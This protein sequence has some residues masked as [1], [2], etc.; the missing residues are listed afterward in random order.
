MTELLKLFMHFYVGSIEESKLGQLSGEIRKMNNN[1]VLSQDPTNACPNCDKE[2]RKEYLKGWQCCIQGHFQ[3]TSGPQ[4]LNK[5]ITFSLDI[6][7]EGIAVLVTSLSL[8]ENAKLSAKEKYLVYQQIID[9]IYDN[10]AIF[11]PTL[12]TL[13]GCVERFASKDPE[14][15]TIDLSVGGVI[16]LG[17][18]YSIVIVEGYDL[19]SKNPNVLLLLLSPDYKG[20]SRVPTHIRLSEYLIEIFG[21]M[22]VYASWET[23]VIQGHV[24]I[25]QIPNY[26]VLNRL[27]LRVWYNCYLIDQL[28]TMYLEAIRKIE[29]TKATLEEQAKY[30][31]D[32]LNKLR[33]LRRKYT[34]IKNSLLEFNPNMSMRFVNLLKCSMLYSN[35]T[36]ILTS[37]QEKLTVLHEDYSHEYQSLEQKRSE[38]I[39]TS[40]Q[41]LAIV[42]ATFGIVQAVDIIINTVALSNMILIGWE[43][44]FGLEIIPLIITLLWFVWFRFK[45]SKS[46]RSE[47]PQKQEAGK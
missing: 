39:N 14:L 7:E 17:I 26:D 37:T 30:V 33:N 15:E 42:V 23:F 32:F 44:R 20:A 19:S 28:A 2:L 46:N 13:R 31:E 6:F 43:I 38:R 1:W 25:D 29:S 9:E 24:Y 10:V 5:D 36:S 8:G 3:L 22:K 45:S 4:F 16:G 40:L 11:L 12:R 27:L 21:D 47:T 35:L 18:A 41:M 34:N